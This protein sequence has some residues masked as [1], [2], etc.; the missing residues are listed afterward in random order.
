MRGPDAGTRL[1]GVTFWPTKAQ[2]QSPLLLGIHLLAWLRDYHRDFVWLPGHD[3][4]PG[5]AIDTLFGRSD[6]RQQLD[7]GLNA[8]E[9]VDSWR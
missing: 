5:G 7:A 2:H 4:S 3:G 6:L 1:P 8:S 9:I